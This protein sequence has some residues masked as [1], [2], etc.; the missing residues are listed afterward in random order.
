MKLLGP[1]RMIDGARSGVA[2]GRW[3]PAPTPLPPLT[4]PPAGKLIKAME[5]EHCKCNLPKAKDGEKE[6]KSES[7]MTFTSSNGLSTFPKDEWEF[8]YRPDRNR[9]DYAQ[10]EV[11]R[12]EDKQGPEARAFT[13]KPIEHRKLEE[14]MELLTL[15]K[16]VRGRMPACKGVYYAMCS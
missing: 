1:P 4:S 5:L 2:E 11:P 13:R 7:E 12:E 9:K 3:R 6:R 10:R 15:E 16:E 14:N 8:V